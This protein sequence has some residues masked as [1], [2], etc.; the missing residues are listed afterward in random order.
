MST[1]TSN[2][3]L[4]PSLVSRGRG[5]A[6]SESALVL[7]ASFVIIAAAKISVPFFPVPMTLQTLAVMAVAASFGMR[8]GTLTVL[9]YFAE[10]L[11]GLPVFANTPPAVAGPL[12]FMGTTGGFLAGFVVLALIVGFAADRG[13]DRSPLK[14]FATILVADAVLFAMGF[15]WL[16]W[17]AH[18][19]S[20]AH[21]VGA[22]VA[23]AKGV[24][25]FVLGDLLK[26]VL[27]AAAV[28]AVWNLIGGA[29]SPR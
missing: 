27:V 19:A 25:P 29:R 14:L 26:M 8:L 12:Y 10:G 5:A 13:L 3:A 1:A 2:A 20:G 22:S 24:L 6:L 16:A 23:W 18:L 17:G 7:L 9:T 11:A 4:A 28:P 15:A 21:G